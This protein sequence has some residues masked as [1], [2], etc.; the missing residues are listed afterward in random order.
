MQIA[1][2]GPAK[3]VDETD[4]NGQKE[5]FREGLQCMHNKGFTGR[6]EFQ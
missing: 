4:E 3:I 2:E 6:R 1:G 5:V